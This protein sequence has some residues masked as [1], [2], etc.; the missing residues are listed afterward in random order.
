MTT[1]STFKRS[2]RKG[3]DPYRHVRVDLSWPKESRVR[4]LDS[5]ARDWGSINSRRLLFSDENITVKWYS[6]AG[7]GGVL[8]FIKSDLDLRL[9]IKADKWIYKT[10]SDEYGCHPNR[11]GGPWT[12][13]E[14]EEDCGWSLLPYVLGKEKWGKVMEKMYP[15]YSH[16][17]KTLEEFK[18]YFTASAVSTAR[19]WYP[20]LLKVD[21]WL[22][23]ETK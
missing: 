7:H 16:M 20:E 4:I 8:M 2:Y 1:I 21:L 3:E 12:I 10:S 19:R 11:I 23:R 22:G 9:E 5:L 17:D 15:M 18:E 6:C 13:L 14:F